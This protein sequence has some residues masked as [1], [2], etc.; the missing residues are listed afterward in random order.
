MESVISLTC[1]VIRL[2]KDINSGMGIPLSLWHAFTACFDSL[3]F[4]S[5]S[6]MV[7][8]YDRHQKDE[9]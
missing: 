5:E 6:S 7:R 8:I 9:S 2:I 1:L 4:D 3:S